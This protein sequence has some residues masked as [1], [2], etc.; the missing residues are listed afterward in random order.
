[1]GNSKKGGHK[2]CL[3][4]SCSVALPHISTKGLPRRAHNSFA[5]DRRATVLYCLFCQHLLFHSAVVGHTVCPKLPCLPCR[6]C[7]PLLVPDLFFLTLFSIFVSKLHHFTCLAARLEP[8]F[9]EQISE[10][11]RTKR[12]LLKDAQWDKTKFFI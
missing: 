1:M 8:S 2:D 9:P 6:A 4:R 12:K 3:K 5:L 7:P 10:K 11:R